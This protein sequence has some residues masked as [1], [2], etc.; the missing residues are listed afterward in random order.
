VRVFTVKDPLFKTEPLFVMGC[1]HQQLDAYLRKHFRV[2]VDI[3]NGHCGQML[4]FDR[5]P[6]RVVWTQTLDIPVALHELFHLV[7]RICQDRG[8]PIRAHN[9]NGEISDEPA[10][11]LYEFFARAMLRRVKARA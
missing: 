8:I 9:A 6:W 5:A 1:S 4:T 10:A 11:Y 2:S 7:T 3:D